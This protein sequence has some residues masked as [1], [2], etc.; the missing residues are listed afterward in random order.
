MRDIP[1]RDEPIKRRHPVC[2]ILTEARSPAACLLQLQE[3]AAK[4][5]TWLKPAPV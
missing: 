3:R 1:H 5:K 2:T 4:L